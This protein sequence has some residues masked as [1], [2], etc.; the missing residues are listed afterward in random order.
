MQIINNNSYKFNPNKNHNTKLSDICAVIVTFNPDLVIFKRV[1]ISNYRSGLR[2][3]IIDNNSQN[4]AKL[5][6]TLISLKYYNIKLILLEENVGLGAAQN[7]GISVARKLECSRL[8][9]FDQD[10]VPSINMIINMVSDE[11]KLIQSGI[12]VGAIGPIFKNPKSDNF[13]ALSKINGMFLDKIFPKFGIGPIEVS[14]LISSGTLIR[15]EV[16]DQVGTM[17]EDFFIDGVDFE[18]CFRAASLGYKFYVSSDSVMLHTVGDSIS[19][20]IGRESFI[21]SPLRRYYITRNSILLARLPWAPF[22]FR[23]RELFMCIIRVP[24]FLLIVKF[25]YVYIFYTLKGIYHGFIGRG[26]KYK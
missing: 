24:Y 13:Y 21:H 17:N 3:I 19:K 9:F 18:W 23:F 1:I 10:S 4:K 11:Y 16:F 5:E 14:Y 22:G 6:E 7:I 26:G 12:N 15:L 2:L 20:Y 8:I 25:N